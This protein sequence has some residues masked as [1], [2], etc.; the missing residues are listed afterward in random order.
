MRHGKLLEARPKGNEYGTGCANS[1]TALAWTLGLCR[2]G[3]TQS[4]VS[5]V[6][7]DFYI[8]LLFF[9]ICMTCG[10]IQWRSSNKNLDGAH[11]HCSVAHHLARRQKDGVLVCDS[12]SRWGSCPSLPHGELRLGGVWVGDLF[13]EKV[14]YTQSNY[15]KNLIFNYKTR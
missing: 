8:L 6:T 12:G 11:R 2:N 13:L 9:I 1:S 7:Q 10:T 5:S 4:P 14:Q 15:H 3:W